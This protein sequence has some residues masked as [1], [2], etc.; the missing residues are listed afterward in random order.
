MNACPCSA[1]QFGVAVPRMG[2]ASSSR[3]AASVQPT[4]E[5]ALVTMGSP[6]GSCLGRPPRRCRA[7]VRARRSPPRARASRGT[8]GSSRPGGVLIRRGRPSSRRARGRSWC[9]FVPWSSRWR[10]GLPGAS[11]APLVCDPNLWC[12]PLAQRCFRGQ[13]EQVAGA[14]GLGAG[15][16]RLLERERELEVIDR[17]IEGVVGGSSGLVLVEGQAGIGKS[18]LVAE[19]RRRAAEGGVVVLSA[20]GGELERE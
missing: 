12:R 6:F 3:A 9:A 14:L 11:R 18:R 19:A 7:I 13:D 1:V 2:A 10:T 17:A 15:A 8:R 16:A 5:S 4:N 20:R